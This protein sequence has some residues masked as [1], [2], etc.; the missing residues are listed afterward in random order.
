[1][2]SN[3]L[4]TADEYLL[5]PEAYHPQRHPKFHDSG[6]VC[7]SNGESYAGRNCCTRGVIIT[8]GIQYY[9]KL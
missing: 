8:G 1:M 5:P 3:L 2:P 7:G 4:S 6:G 9:K